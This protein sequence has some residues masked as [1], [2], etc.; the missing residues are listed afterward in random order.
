MARASVFLLLLPIFYLVGTAKSASTTTTTNFIETSCRATT[1]PQV[2]I[3]SLSSYA[4]SIQQSPRQL[5]Q[6]ALSVSLTKAKSAKTFVTK[7]AKF[8]GLKSREYGAIKDCLE[9]MGDSV[10]RMSKSVTELKNMGKSKGQDFL[11]HMSNVET[12]VSAAL[13]DDN[14]CLDGFSGK[15]LNGKIKSSVRAQVLNVA[16]CTSNALALCNR[17]AGNH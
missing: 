8:K 16:Q 2:C 6:A 1:Y 7:L 17:F 11:W 5:A 9:E 4:N 13:T 12:W 14:T 15:A 3:Q 10:D